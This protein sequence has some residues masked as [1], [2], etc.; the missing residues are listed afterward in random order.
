MLHPVCKVD[1]PKRLADRGQDDRGDILQKAAGAYLF[2]R[3]FAIE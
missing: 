2:A 3:L 1:L